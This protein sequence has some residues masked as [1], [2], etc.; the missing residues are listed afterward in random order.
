MDRRRFISCTPAFA[1]I[2]LTG[3]A[4]GADAPTIG[5]LWVRSPDADTRSDM[6]RRA[7]EAKGVA[8]PR[9]EIAAL[10]DRYEG[11]DEAARKLVLQKVDIVVAHGATAATAAARATSSI[12]IV[13]LVTNDPVALK[14]V[15]S[16]SR[17]GRNATGVRLSPTDMTGKRFEFLKRIVP[18]ARRVGHLFNVSSTAENANWESMRGMAGSVGLQLEAVTVRTAGDIT[19]AI[20]NA[21]KSGVDAIT[22]AGSTM[23]V[24]NARRVIDAVAAA[25]LPAVYPNSEYADAGGLLSYGPNL[26]AAFGLAAGY[27]ARIAKGANPATLP[28]E[29]SSSYELIANLRTAKAQGITI[30]QDLIGLA[31]RVIDS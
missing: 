8:S 26:A 19:P 5:L 29:Q 7:L 12:P 21:A 22:A 2:A 11:L 6:M 17:P 24:A 16:L 25:R 1:S 15:A 13:F 4:W 9:L 3:S 18:R 20:A 10:P 14:L 28:V 30:P 31:D 27:V 23:L